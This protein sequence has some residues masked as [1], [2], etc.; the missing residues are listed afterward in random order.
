MNYSFI[1]LGNNT[2]YLQAGFSKLHDAREGLHSI[3]NL[4][5][6]NKGDKGIGKVTRHSLDKSVVVEE[7]KYIMKCKKLH[8]SD[9]IV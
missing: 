8:I 2:I 4:Y 1:Y 5:C 7:F 9:K 6:N 3:V